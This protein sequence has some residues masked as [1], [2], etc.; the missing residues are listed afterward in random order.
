MLYSAAFIVLLIAMLGA[1]PLLAL[2]ASDEPRNDSGKPLGEQRRATPAV[3]DEPGH[4]LDAA[5]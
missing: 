2:F 3:P 5:A 4:D 1:A